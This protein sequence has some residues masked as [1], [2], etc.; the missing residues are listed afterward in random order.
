MSQPGAWG[1]CRIAP[2]RAVALA[3]GT[4]ASLAGETDTLRRQRL[5]AVSVFLAATYGLLAVWVFASDNPGT[6][7]AEGGRFSFRAG[8][9]GLRCLLAAAVAGLLASEAPL[10]RKAAPRRRIRAVPR[11][12]SGDDRLPVLRRPRPGASRP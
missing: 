10:G 5:L 8:M 4:L 1:E 6:L 12:D 7:T 9:V 3:E 11:P 2:T